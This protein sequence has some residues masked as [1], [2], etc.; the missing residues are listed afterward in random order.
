MTIH[1]QIKDKKLQCHINREA[2]K[3]STL[4]KILGKLLLVK[5]MIKSL[6]NVIFINKKGS[7]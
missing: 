4:L 6:N 7:I 1:D 5:E 3:I 2:A